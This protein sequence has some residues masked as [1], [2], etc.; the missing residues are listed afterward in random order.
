MVL[1]DEPDAVQADLELVWRMAGAAAGLAVEVDQRAEARRLAADD[2]DHERQPEGSGADEGLGCSADADPDRERVLQRSGEDALA[3][4]RWAV[5]SG[6]RDL[7][8]FA[9]A[10]QEVELLG[11]QRVVVG[12][13]E[14]EQRKGLGERAAADD[15]VDPALGDQIE[16]REL[17]EE[18]YGIACAE[19]GHG[20]VETDRGRPGCGCREEDRG[21][22]VH[23]IVAVVLAD[24]VGVEADLVGALDLFEQVLHALDGAD[25]H[26]GNGIR[27]RRDEA[28]YA[29][30]H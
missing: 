4:E 10:Q 26:T 18:P 21:R 16:G 27:D 30:T 14:P 3:G 8:L 19:D 12:E 24:A 13:I 23:E 15:E 11:E 22:G 6:P 28:V 29:D 17:L 2:R 5:P 9:D 7:R 1:A 25:V 20:A